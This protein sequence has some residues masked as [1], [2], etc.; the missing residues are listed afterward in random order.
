MF[1]SPTVGVFPTQAFD[2]RTAY[3]DNNQ[4]SIKEEETFP[5]DFSFF[6]REN[7]VEHAPSNRTSSEVISFVWSDC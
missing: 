1:P 4:Q 5:S 7:K 6:T 2:W 3:A